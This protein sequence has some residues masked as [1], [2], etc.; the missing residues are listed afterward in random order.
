MEN[1]L[2]ETLFEKKNTPERV[3]LHCYAVARKADDLADK[4]EE[5]GWILNRELLHMAAV[6]HDVA[7]TEKDHAVAGA[8]W[9]TQQGYPEVGEI[10]ACHHW[11]NRDQEKV[12]SE[13]TVLYL[14]DKLV[15]E[16]REVSIE[17]RFSGSIAKCDT[18][19]ARAL[20]R[21][22]YE[23]AKQVERMILDAIAFEGT[24]QESTSF[25]TGCGRDRK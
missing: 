6:L 7:R 21:Y 18:E 1:Q 24:A 23:Q 12:I 11:L 9:V 2:F 15:Q 20:H 5:K 13:K 19:E 4:L 17:E 10:I 3:R 8:A 16:D 25:E 14:V 22:R